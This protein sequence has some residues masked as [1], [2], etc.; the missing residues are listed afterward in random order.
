MTIK[1]ERLAPEHK[2]HFLDT[3]LPHEIAH[4]WWGNGVPPWVAEGSAV[5]AS[6]HFLERTRGLD[7]AIALLDR[8]IYASFIS[9]SV[10]P[11]PLVNAQGV[12]MYAK[13]DISC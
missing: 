7:T 3:Y 10:T 2:Q 5:F 6:A 4:C 13:G 8:D 12:T 9:P 11:A 1:P